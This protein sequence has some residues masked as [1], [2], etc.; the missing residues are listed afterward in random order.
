MILFNRCNL[1]PIENDYEKDVGSKSDVVTANPSIIHDKWVMEEN[2][3]AACLSLNP[4]AQHYG[5]L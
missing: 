2:M 1:P 3:K 5:S 4:L